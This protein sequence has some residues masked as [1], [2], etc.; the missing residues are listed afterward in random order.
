MPLLLLPFWP[1]TPEREK[2]TIDQTTA[3]T[4]GEINGKIEIELKRGGEKGKGGQTDRKTESWMET[5]YGASV[6]QI[7]S[8]NVKKLPYE[9]T[10]WLWNM[11][12]NENETNT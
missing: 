4:N 8:Q 11:G 12:G 9:P 2:R 1:E 5:K 6:P 3:T 7:Q 10:L